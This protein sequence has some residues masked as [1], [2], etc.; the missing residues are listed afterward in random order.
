MRSLSLEAE[1]SKTV[2]KDGKWQLCCSWICWCSGF[3]FASQRPSLQKAC[4]TVIYPFH[5]SSVQ[6]DTSDCP[7]DNTVMPWSYSTKWCSWQWFK[8][9]RS[10]S[11]LKS[12]D[13]KH[14]LK[15]QWQIF[16][17]Q[18]VLMKNTVRSSS[19]YLSSRSYLQVDS[20]N[21]TSLR[22]VHIYATIGCRTGQF[23][24]PSSK[25][26]SL[27]PRTNLLDSLGLPSCTTL[28][29]LQARTWQAPSASRVNITNCAASAT[30]FL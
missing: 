28:E 3:S 19:G 27:L 20:S 29:T 5:W 6:W 21:Y 30:S 18:Y 8:P 16:V 2:L 17:P 7:V 10:M 12:Q 14:F 11:R 13:P 24:Q 9:L 23:S 4:H 22:K 25:E 15:L 1:D 26:L